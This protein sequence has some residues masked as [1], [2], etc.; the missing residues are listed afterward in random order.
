ML[1]RMFLECQINEGLHYP[2]DYNDYFVFL[3]RWHIYRRDQFPVAR[4]V[5]R[6][7]FTCVHH[8]PYRRSRR[9]RPMRMA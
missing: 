5:R 1:R 7:N 3:V 9:K 4:Q 6:L 2:T 8:H